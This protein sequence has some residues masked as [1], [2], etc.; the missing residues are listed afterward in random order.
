VLARLY[1]Q[2]AHPRAV[3][4]QITRSWSKIKSGT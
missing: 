1:V 2:E 4:R 3:Q